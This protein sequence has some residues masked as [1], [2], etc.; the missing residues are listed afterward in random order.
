MTG[1]RIEDLTL[2]E[3]KKRKKSS[4]LLTWISVII[5]IAAFTLTLLR[6]FGI[7]YW[8]KSDTLIPSLLILV[9]IA[10]VLYNLWKINREIKRRENS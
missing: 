6:Y 1:K 10:V 3:L 2:E 8:G 9:I 7:G 4:S 5:F